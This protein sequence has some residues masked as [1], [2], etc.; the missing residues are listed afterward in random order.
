MKKIAVVILAGILSVSVFAGEKEDLAR[1]IELHGKA[2]TGNEKAL[3]E[4]KKILEPYLE[5]NMTA[6]AYYGSA[7]TIEAGFVSEK[8]PVKALEFL[9]EGSKLI[10]E[11]VKK[12]PENLELRILRLGNG[13]E[14]SASSPY[15]RYFV[16]QND[17]KFFENE[18]KLNQLD[19][20]T[21]A[22][23]YL[24]M[25]LFKIEEGDLDAALDYLDLAVE[26]A[27]GSDYAKKAEK[28]LNRYE[29]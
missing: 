16:I 9:E 5:K 25:G 10:D 8:N 27:P 17:V 18:K 12:E 7:V 29:E 14:V 28:V 26:C 11:A 15:K 23:V 24:N 13:I 4:C 21:K 6:K 22:Y 19:D 20:E 3:M 2:G 1:G